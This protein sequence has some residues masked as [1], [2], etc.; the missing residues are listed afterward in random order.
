MS[1]D[2]LIVGGGPVGM[3]LGAELARYGVSVRIVH[4]TSQE[5]RQEPNKT[6]PVF[7]W[8]RTLEL[9]D[10]SGC[11]ADFVAAGQKLT[12]ANIV[13]DGKSI[14]HIDFT[15]VDSTHRYLLTLPQDDTERFLEQHLNRLGVQVE[16]G[17]SFISLSHTGGALDR[18][19]G[20]KVVIGH[21]DGGHEIVETKWLV[22]CDGIQSGVRKYMEMPL[23]GGSRQSDWAMA[24]VHLTGIGL[25]P[26]EFTTFWH[27][28][29][30][31]AIFPIQQGAYRIIADLGKGPGLWPQDPT[32]SEI[33]ALLDK[34]G[35]G[36]LTVTDP[37]WL[38]AFRAS[39]KK[40][41][42]YQMG[43]VF[44]S[45]DAAYAYSPMGGQGLNMG[46]QDS[47]NL[48]WKLALVVKGICPEEKLLPSYNV[49]R[50]AATAQVTGTI[51]RLTAAANVRN[52]PIQTIRNLL[53]GAL[54]GLL[55]TRR[56]MADSL[57]EI[58]IGYT[59]SPL[60]GPE[61]RAF[62]GPG[63]GD[64]MPPVA[65]EV[66]VGAGRVPRFAL[67]ADAS[68]EINEVLQVH[69]DLLEPTLRAPLSP[70]CVWLVRPDGYVAAVSLD[71]DVKLIADYLTDLKEP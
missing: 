16:R 52:Q 8:S 4:R 35:P 62:P 54:L 68:P 44:L 66:P 40:V 42:N 21:S 7:L 15:S 48:A 29:G 30:V 33:Q 45:G 34:R 27:H 6:K 22:G 9:L 20:L 65:G 3:T 39:D 47:V 19:M 12:A 32:L 41:R 24:D 43:R 38:S 60:N 37:L 50:S 10:R 59:H 14:G 64:R 69:A 46:M 70:H 18:T 26:S 25:N 63:P 58:S 53:G 31:L 49:E 23:Q 71:L 55:P 36:G 56:V 67:Y 51:S 61:E 17:S 57:A 1:I 11:A 5:I 2:V 28:D 13:S